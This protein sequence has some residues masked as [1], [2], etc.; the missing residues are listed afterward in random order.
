[1][2]TL[3]LLLFPALMFVGCGTNQGGTGD[4][5]SIYNSSGQ[6]PASTRSTGM[7]GAGTGNAGMGVGTG[8]GSG[9]TGSGPR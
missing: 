2:K 5:Y 4:A 3:L 1:M 7:L 9:S 8:L 6:N